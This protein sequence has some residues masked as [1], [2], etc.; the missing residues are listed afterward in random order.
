MPESAQPD[1]DSVGTNRPHNAGKLRVFIS[2]SR[3]DLDFADQLD[4][5]LD[6]YAFDCT[7]DRQGISGGEDWRK[8]LGDLI[9]N[10]DTVIFVL[11]PSSAKSEICAWEVDEAARFGKRIIP[12]N[13]RPLDG[14]QPPQRLRELNYIYFYADPKSPGSGF[15]TGLQRLVSA[16][17]ADLDWLR[18]HTRLLQRA[19]E[20]VAGGKPV[21]RLLS[22]ADI[23]AAK[24]WAAIQ[25]KDAPAPTAEHLDFIRASEQEEEARTNAERQQLATMAAAQDE[26]AKALTQA[27]EALKHAAEAQRSRARARNIALAV[28]SVLGVLAGFL[29]IRAEQ[30]RQRVASILDTSKELIHAVSSRNSF[31]EEEYKKAVAVFLIG[32]EIGHLSDMIFMGAAYSHGWGVEPDKGKAREWLDK[33][34]ARGDPDAMDLIGDLYHVT[35]DYAK[36]LEWYEKGAARG[37]ANA[38]KSIGHLY[39]NGQG[40]ALSESKAHE[41]YEKAAAKGDVPAMNNLAQ[42]YVEGR[43]VPKSPSKAQEWYEKA[44]ATGNTAAMANL[45]QRYADGTGVTKDIVKARELYERAAVKG[46]VGAM[47]SLAQL[48][49][50]GQG[51]EKPDYAKAH[52]WFEKAAAKDDP[53]AMIELGLLYNNGHGVV[54][55]YSKAREWFQKAVTKSGTTVLT[56]IGRRYLEGV[57]VTRDEARAR[58]WLEKAAAMGDGDAMYRLGLLS[59]KTQRG[60]PDYAKA[61]EW[62]EKGVE[63]GDPDAMVA[64]GMLYDNGHGVLKDPAKAREL[65]EM[66]AAKSGAFLLTS[67]GR[68]YLDGDGL[69]KDA[70]KAREWFERG[71]E[72]GDGDAMYRLG[73]LYEEGKVVEKDYKKARE[74]FEKGVEKDDVDAL[75]SLGFFYENGHDVKKDYGK[76][77]ALYER[78]AAKG[79]SYAM[80]VLGT[81]YHDALG[82]NKDW[83]KA[84]EWYEKAIASGSD[85]AK[86]NLD[87]L[88]MD[89]AVAA[90][91]Y[92]E[93]L[94]LQ[95]AQTERIVAAE[96]KEH[97]KPGE[98]TAGEL[99]RQS[100]YA[101]LAREYTQALATGDRAIALSLGSLHID[102]NRAHALLLLGRAAEARALYLAHK[103]KPIA[104]DDKR[105]WE[106]VIAEDFAELRKAGL[107]HPMIAEIEKELSISR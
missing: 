59:T 71:A 94:K 97:G 60:A 42:R 12:V 26:R 45:A 70:A 54:Q 81:F 18:E 49:A 80:S 84:R 16:L 64:L 89:E 25:P 6:L 83:E 63:S 52:E 30:Q 87:R 31:N 93:A 65:Y 67:I 20:W 56:K 23:A 88:A 36:A 74:W 57:G 11:S 47:R 7:I 17:N 105:T 98:E 4:A 107:S 40:V 102:T 3:D 104:S 33:A 34:V 27:E 10:A 53:D 44:A 106:Q 15:G 90:G 69:P 91:R 101:L 51:L 48:N 78:A 43:G 85:L 100:W 66:A 99:L 73:S 29:G 19:G 37:G 35:Q 46:N 38:M 58:E 9:R 28:V 5:A 50:A 24:R 61:R 72:A 79:G 76:A 13:C 41:W 2:Y 14:N 8:R 62:Y 92:G 96:T 1:A 77:R 103:G 22:G 68:R 75:T 39:D 86:T 21:N 55:D 32:A 82:V 95:A